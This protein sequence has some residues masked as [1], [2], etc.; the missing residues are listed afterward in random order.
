L[1]RE[2]EPAEEQVTT[3]TDDVDKSGEEFLQDAELVGTK[4]K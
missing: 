3:S 2:T 4:K 1:V